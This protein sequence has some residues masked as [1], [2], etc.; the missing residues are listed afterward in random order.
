MKNKK[1]LKKLTLTASI[2]CAMAAPL[3]LTGCTDGKN[4]KS[5][6]EIAVENGFK[7]TESEWLESLKQKPRIEIID[8]YWYV[9]GVSTGIKATGDTGATGPQGPQGTTGQQ[10]PQ[11]V[12]GPQGTAGVGVTNMQAE[13]FFNAE[14][15]A[16]I[17][18]TITYSN[19]DVEH[20]I[21]VLKERP[22]QLY[23]NNSN[24]YV[25]R[26]EDNEFPTIRFSAQYENEDN[27]YN[28]LLT[29]AMILEGSIQTNTLGNYPITV[30]YN[31]RKEN[32][33][34][35]VY[36]PTNVQATN[37][38][39]SYSD[40]IMKKDA[41]GEV[42]YDYSNVYASVTYQDGSSKN[43]KLSDLISMDGFQMSENPQD[44]YTQM[45]CE[46][47]GVQFSFNVYEKTEEELQ[48]MASS[49]TPSLFFSSW[50]NRTY[51]CL[52]GGQPYFEDLQFA[53]S[54]TD[55]DNTVYLPMELTTELLSGFS[56]TTKGENT[57]SFDSSKVYNADVTGY[58]FD[59]LVYELE[60]VVELNG[61]LDGYIKAG[62]NDLSQYEV[63]LEHVIPS[64]QNGSTYVQYKKVT[65]DELGIDPSEF[66]TYGY[67]EVQGTYE[68]K[69]YILS[70][71]VYDLAVT[72]IESMYVE[73]N[74]E[75]TVPK[76]A[77]EEE[78]LAE[79][80]SKL[81]GKTLNVN[82]YEPV[83]GSNTGSVVITAE[84][85]DV[86]NVSAAHSG[87]QSVKINYQGAS[88]SEYLMVIGDQPQ[89]E[90]T[91][92]TISSNMNE[93]MVGFATVD[94]YENGVALLD[95]NPIKM[96][97]Y[98]I[99]EDEDPTDNKQ[100]I[101][102]FAN[103]YEL[104]YTVTTDPTNGNVIDYLEI[105]GD[106][107]T[108]TNNQ[109]GVSV[110]AKVYQSNIIVVEMGGMKISVSNLKSDNTFLVVNMVCKLNNDGETFDIVGEL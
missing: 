58:Q 82:Y 81:V 17:R 100:N 57:Y 40:I 7:G 44:G 94:V 12:Q 18:F 5:A 23:F 56:N 85:I 88:D 75:M 105:E 26:N 47:K 83:N 9:D 6:Y 15:K 33:T 92:Y 4:G 62:T 98:E 20:V 107:T 60:D 72:N 108:Y 109:T 24:L 77:T 38:N 11:G 22:T 32:I 35:T 31:G 76:G 102:V 103:G 14:G 71:E 104:F 69:T 41:S 29:S 59:I 52:V 53:L 84:M 64:G 27:E 101:K 8:G 78:I 10:G 79:A 106:C 2:C 80:V 45:S 54:F 73:G 30:G 89:G 1:L 55:N 110:H 90:A 19:E 43:F 16:C 36:D 3:F 48:A 28:I 34:V 99:L 25:P 46:Y 66:A 91:T 65:L 51:G 37:V 42:N 63:T 13:Y 96:V 74:V 93:D 86:S 49:N 68:G 67:K 50:S 70:I 21:V 87:V 61:Y 97:D 39:P 95:G